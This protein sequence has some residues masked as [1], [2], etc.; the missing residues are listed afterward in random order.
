M[1][2]NLRTGLAVLLLLGLSAATLTVARV[3]GRRALA[4]AS[5]RAAAQLALVGGLVTGVLRAPPEAAAFLALMLTV[6]CA[7]TAKRLRALRPRLVHVAVACL[8]GSVVTVPL[9]LVT[10]ALPS[11]TRY[12]LALSGITLGGTMTASTLAGRRLHDSLLRRRDEVEAWLALG[13]PPARRWPT[14]SAPRCPRPWCRRR[15]DPH[16]RARNS[17]RGLRRRPCRRRERG[18]RSAV[19]ADRPDHAAHRRRASPPAC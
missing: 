2:A 4:T 10:G 14:S 16:G 5:L 7:T 17:S 12:V 9:V 13:R 3:P 8:A 15:P 6:A 18:R 19:P 1:T 11:T